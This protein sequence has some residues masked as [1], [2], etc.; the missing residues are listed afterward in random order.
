VA[1][2]SMKLR[3][4]HPMYIGGLHGKS[5]DLHQRIY[6]EVNRIISDQVK[7]TLPREQAKKTL[8]RKSKELKLTPS[9]SSK[10]FH[11]TYVIEMLIGQK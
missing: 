1:S 7:T 10:D 9:S 4:S 11:A 8:P 5:F 3:L 6:H 2:K